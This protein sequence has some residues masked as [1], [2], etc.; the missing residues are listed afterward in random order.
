MSSAV[1]L[2]YLVSVATSADANA[3]YRQALDEFAKCLVQRHH[4]QAAKLVLALGVNHETAATISGSAC[5]SISMSIA[6]AALQA[7]LANA[8]VNAEATAI[9]PDSI[10]HAPSLAQPVL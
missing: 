10:K 9:E 4:R 3:Q 1:L 8:L 5:A 6:P 7:A 2:A